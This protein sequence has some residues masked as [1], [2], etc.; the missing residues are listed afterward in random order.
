M[1]NRCFCYIR[2]E[3]Y[4]GYEFTVLLLLSGPIKYI[5]PKQQRKTS[6]VEYKSRSSLVVYPAVHLFSILLF[7]LKR[8]CFEYK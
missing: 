4:R 3:Y 8:F 1:T 5:P 2:G 6:R 7:L